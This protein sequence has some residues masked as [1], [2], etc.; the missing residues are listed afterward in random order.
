[1]ARGQRLIAS[2]ILLGAAMIAGGWVLEDEGY[3]S[4][5]LLQIGSTVLLIAPLIYVERTINRQI[6]G[7]RGELEA[8]RRRA[9]AVAVPYERLRSEEPSSHMRTAV[10]E[11]QMA[12]AR[13][14]A[15][16]GRH[17]P[18]EVAALFAAGSEGE[19]IYALGLMQGSHSLL[20][21]DAV[22]DVILRSRSAFE[23]YQGLLLAQRAWDSMTEEAQR[24]VLDAIDAQMEPGG[25]IT[26]GSDRH[27]IARAIKLDA[28][29]R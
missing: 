18:A 11:R 23:Q 25:R 22:V 8:L 7:V 4:A 20:S 5:L 10:M 27:E 6:G 28:R 26:A 2:I 14:E 1:M 15:T 13:E 3:V 21:V 24:H 16:R 19:R 12:Q 9:E 29:T 17:D